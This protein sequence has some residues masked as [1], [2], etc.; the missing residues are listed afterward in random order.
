MRAKKGPKIQE[1][2]ESQLSE[3]ERKELEA[4]S[5]EHQKKK[6]MVQEITEA[7]PEWLFYC[8]LST[9]TNV[10]GK[11]ETVEFWD[12]MI[13]ELINRSEEHGVGDSKDRLDTLAS[14]FRLPTQAD[15]IEEFDGLNH[16]DARKLIFVV[17][18]PVIM[19]GHAIQLKVAPEI[20]HIR[21][22]NLYT[23]PLGLPVAMV[24]PEKT[25]AFFDCKLR[26]LIVVLTVKRPE[27]QIE[28]PAEDETMEE[29]N[30]AGASEEASQ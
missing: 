10:L 4:K 30:A 19:R 20:V 17:S 2:G 25:Q 18:L 14:A 7:T 16:E 24:V 27:D 11:L 28:E 23:L 29:G 15:I 8:V 26:K 1:M 6:M 21:V 5:L 13:T 12:K 3:E 9:D 22:P